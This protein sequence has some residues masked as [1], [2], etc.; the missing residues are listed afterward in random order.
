MI[1]RS[2]VDAWSAVAETTDL[3]DR[4][5]RIPPHDRASAAR[6]TLLR[7]CLVLREMQGDRY[8]ERR[9]EVLKDA[10]RTLLH[11]RKLREAGSATVH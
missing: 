7:N 3:L 4:F 5:A 8:S 9:R 6:K 10:Q 1:S 2:T 11:L